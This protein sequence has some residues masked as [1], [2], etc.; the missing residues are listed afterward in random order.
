MQLLC[1]RLMSNISDKTVPT[2]LCNALIEK[3]KKLA[4]ARQL[5]RCKDHTQFQG[6]PLYE[7]VLRG[8]L[9]QTLCIIDQMLSPHQREQQQKW[10][11][12]GV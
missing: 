2:E 12:S 10:R 6:R 9:E 11:A 1:K 7:D 4:E 8:E 3:D 5:L